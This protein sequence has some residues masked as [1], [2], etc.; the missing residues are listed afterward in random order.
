M[1]NYQVRAE[2]ALVGGVVVLVF[3]DGVVNFRRTEFIVD[4][5]PNLR[6]QEQPTH[7]EHDI[8]NSTP[9][10]RE[11]SPQVKLTS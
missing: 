8:L 2:I 1:N 5:D 9:P 11:Q 7:T 10:T 3:R 6:P 4:A